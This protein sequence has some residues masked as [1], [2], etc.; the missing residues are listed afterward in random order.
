M[1]G[2]VRFQGLEGVFYSAETVRFV[3]SSQE[4]IES[5]LKIT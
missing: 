1:H 5:E 3:T 4:T 2:S